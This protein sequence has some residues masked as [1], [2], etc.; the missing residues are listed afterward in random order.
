MTIWVDADSCPADV[1]RVVKK[2]AARLNVFAHFVANRTIPGIEN[3]TMTEMI[4]TGTEEGSAD[5]YIL[6]N[7]EVGDLVITRDIPLAAELVEREICVINDRGAVY[8]GENIRQRL[9]ER[10]FMK[11]LREAGLKQPSDRTY[12]HRELKAFAAAFDRETRRLLDTRN[13]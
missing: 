5:R 10:N 1:R 7:S 11:D 6:E 9:S 2:G 12:G 4:L 13:E 8:T 3:N